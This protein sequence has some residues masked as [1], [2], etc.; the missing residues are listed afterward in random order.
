[1]LLNND[2]DKAKGAS[3]N[4]NINTRRIKQD[5]RLYDIFVTLEPALALIESMDA[6]SLWSALGL[7]PYK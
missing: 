6:S 5:A 1:M 4:I 3:S 7:R 2:L